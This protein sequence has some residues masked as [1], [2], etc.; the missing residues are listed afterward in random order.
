M[1]LD[2]CGVEMFLEEGFDDGADDWHLLAGHTGI[3]QQDQEFANYVESMHDFSIL[4]TPTGNKLT[5]KNMST[6]LAWLHDWKTGS[7]P[8]VSHHFM[9]HTK[10]KTTTTWHQ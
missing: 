9:P 4:L 10:H 2:V 1:P 3:M 8:Y 5:V 6:A 7:E